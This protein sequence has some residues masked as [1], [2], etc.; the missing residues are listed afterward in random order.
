MSGVFKYAAH[1]DRAIAFMTFFERPTGL[2]PGVY[3]CSGID[4]AP[5]SLLKYFG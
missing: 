5:L 3:M 2:L 1:L 4:P